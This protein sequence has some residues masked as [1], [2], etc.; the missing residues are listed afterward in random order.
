MC[1]RTQIEFPGEQFL[2]KKPK[3][4]EDDRGDD[5]SCSFGRNFDAL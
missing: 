3:N 2:M 5:R 1:G 4:G